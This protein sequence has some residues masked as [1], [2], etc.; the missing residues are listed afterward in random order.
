[1]SA[2]VR[3][4]RLLESAF[5]LQLGYRVELRGSIADGSVELDAQCQ[6]RFPPCHTPDT[7]IVHRGDRPSGMGLSILCHEDRA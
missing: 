3:A 7:G 4:S 5:A 2:D 6:Y 1:M